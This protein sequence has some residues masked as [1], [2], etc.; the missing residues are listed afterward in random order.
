MVNTVDTFCIVVLSER[1]AL[2]LLHQAMMVIDMASIGGTFVCCRR[3]FC[4]IKML[5]KVHAMVHLN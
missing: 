1:L 3:L 4:L 2:D 5:L